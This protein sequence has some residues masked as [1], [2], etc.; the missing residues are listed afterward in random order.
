MRN[1]S[2]LCS[3]KNSRTWGQDAWKKIVVCIVADGRKKV[4]PRVLDVLALLGVYQPG[5]HMKNMVNNKPVTAHLFEYTTT[6]GLDPNMH[7][8]YPDK[9]VVPTQILFCMKEK[10]QK[11]INSHRWFFNAF[12]PLLQPNICVLLDV[13]TMPTPKSMY[14]LWKAFDMNSNVGGACGEIAA[15]KGKYWYSLFNPLGEQNVPR[16]QLCLH[17]L[18]FLKWRRRILN[19]RLPTFWTSPPNHCSAIS[20]C[21]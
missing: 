17:I 6:F 9:G 11:K 19:T 2:H 7:F 5:D 3:R 16:E 10:N 20:V 18:L 1:I 4:A 8:R 12:G 13:G 21:L 15:Y 14:H